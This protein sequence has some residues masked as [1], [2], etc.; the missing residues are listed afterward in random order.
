M[1][2]RAT[3]YKVGSCEGMLCIA[4]DMCGIHSNDIS[5]WQAHFACMGWQRRCGRDGRNG[6][7]F[8]EEINGR[9]GLMV[10]T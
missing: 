10:G 5:G 3:F 9:Q 8:F 6:K 4:Y 2:F 1:F 7:T